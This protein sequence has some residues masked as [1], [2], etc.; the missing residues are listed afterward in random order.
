MAWIESLD[1]GEDV[2]EQIAEGT[3]IDG[4]D[5]IMLP[6]A[7]PPR[8]CLRCG[9]P[10]E[11]FV[12]REPSQ[13]LARLYSAVRLALGFLSPF[14]PRFLDERIRIVPISVVVPVCR[15]HRRRPAR[16]R[17]DDRFAP[18]LNTRFVRFRGAAWAI[19]AFRAVHGWPPDH[20]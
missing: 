3:W 13:P 7:I 8:V 4:A 2:A 10:A 11:R 5:V 12:T 16:P 18:L 17:I 19:E 6:D 9:A 14:L 1:D 20:E 15:A